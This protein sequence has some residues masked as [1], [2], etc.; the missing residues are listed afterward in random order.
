MSTTA[1][2]LPDTLVH[3]FAPA[4]RRDPYPA[5]R[6]L[7]THAPV[8]HDPFSGMWLVTGHAACS[9]LLRDARF[10]AALGQRERARDDRLPV[11]ML[12]TDPPDHQRLRAPGGLLL[13]PAALRSITDGLSQDVD[14]VLDALARR[15][16]EPDAIRDLGTPLA[17]AVFGRLFGLPAHEHPAFTTLAR[18]ASVNL[19]PMTPPALAARGRLAAGA[20]TRYLDAH[21]RGLK[22]RGD[23]S[24]P[25]AALADDDRLERG[26][27]LG[28]LSLAVIGGWQPLAETVGNG[29]LWLLP[30]AATVRRQL[31]EDPEFARSCVDELLRLEAPIPFAARVATEAVDLPGGSVPAGARVLAVIAAANRDPAVFSDP[32]LLVPDRRPNPHLAFG[33]GA[34]FCLAAAL[35]RQVLPTLLARLLARFPEL[36]GP[37]VPPAWEPT[38]VPRRLTAYPLRLGPSGPPTGPTTSEGN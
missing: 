3:P 26:E 1:V 13:G 7:Q 31:V 14:A 15:R 34:H 5:Y 22:A 38:L 25:L 20:L 9:A 4:G 2:T 36:R 24:A 12:T 16:D 11:S 10:S 19:D 23:T 27:M 30:H 32:D 35:V 18:A 28:I 6:W 21:A 33:A 8:H 29:L 17:T 37:D